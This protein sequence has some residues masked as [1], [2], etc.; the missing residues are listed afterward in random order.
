[1]PGTPRKTVK[2]VAPPSDSP[3]EGAFDLLSVL[4]TE[5]LPPQPVTLLGVDAEI[6]RSYTPEEDLAFGAYLR[7]FEIKELL[8]LMAGDEGG[9]ALYEKFDELTTEQGIKVVNHLAKISTLV[10]GKVMG[11]SPTSTRR[12]VGA[13]QSSG[14]AA[15][16]S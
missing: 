14:S 4:G 1:M 6:R 15:T 7:R 11:L 12:M 10:E 5:D 16:S 2:K 9:A 3:V 8:V 13:P